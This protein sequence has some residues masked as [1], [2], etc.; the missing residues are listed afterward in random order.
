MEPRPPESKDPR[1]SPLRQWLAEGLRQQGGHNFSGAILAYRKVLREDP[2]QVDALCNLGACYRELGRVEEASAMT[3]RALAL[4][5][6]NLAA[7]CNKGSIL[8]DERRFDEA[9]AIFTAVLQ[10]EPQSFTGRFQMAGALFRLGRWEEAQALDRAIVRDSPRN[11]AA[12]S[13]LGFVLLRMGRLAEAR[14]S[15]LRAL[16]LEPEFPSARWNLAYVEL[17]DGR[18]EEAWPHFAFRL[19]IRDGMQNIRNFEVPEW[20]G[21]PFP[22]KRL[23][24]WAEQGFGDTIQFMRFLPQVKALGGEVVLQV[25]PPLLSLLEGHPGVDRIMGEHEPP[26]AVDLHTSLLSLLPKLRLTPARIAEIQPSL[27]VPATYRP[28]PELEAALA[29][30]EGRIRIGLAWTGNPAHRDQDFR[31]IDPEHFRPLAALGEA[32]W[33]DFQK[34]APGLTPRAM[35][36]ELNAVDLAPFLTSFADTAWALQRM[37]LVIS[38]D[39]SVVHLAGCLGIPTFLL[40]PFSPDWRWLQAGDATTWYPSMRLYRQRRLGDWDE[41]VGRVLAD[42]QG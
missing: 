9:I 24:I 11:A 38:A 13:N 12:H 1:E 28:A 37:N 10:R 25:Q 21:Q 8:A 35:P 7:L 34:P 32:A 18:W 30:S 36:A 41:V 19:K 4:D 20:E 6:Q 16:E 2:D 14:Q 39:T 15:I 5:P 33:F 17:L 22:G 3:E 29:A 40:L 26:P 31:T 23:L 27:G 42:L